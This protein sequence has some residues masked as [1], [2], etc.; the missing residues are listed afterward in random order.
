[1]SELT[2][3][4]INRGNALTAL[5][6]RFP[7]PG[8]WGKELTE[9]S[10][11]LASDIAKERGL[12]WKIWLED[13]E[14]RHAGGIYLFEDRAAAERYREK[15]ERRLSAMGLTGATANTFSVNTE[16]SVLTMAGASLGQT[17]VSKSASTP[18]VAAR[19]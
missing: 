9:A 12:V 15:H 11:A 3:T 1:M 5:L 18:A 19:S 4:E 6:F 10:Y 8:P 2:E 13:R 16:L 14:T 17:R 7:F